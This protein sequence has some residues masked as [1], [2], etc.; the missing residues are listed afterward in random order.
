MNFNYQTCKIVLLGESGVGKTCIISQFVNQTFQEDVES[1][2]SGTFSSKTLIYNN[3]QVLKLEIW[4][5]A[6]QE[7][8]RSIA[9]MFYKEADVAILVYDITRKE[10]FE[11]IK[12]YWLNQI[13]E[14]SPENIILALCG[15]KSDLINEEQ[16]DEEEARNY[17]EE[18][19]AIFYPTSAKNDCGITD[20]FLQIAKK[21]TKSD[22]VRLKTDKDEIF[23]S[24]MTESIA[25]SQ[26][27]GSVIITKE[28]TKKTNGVKKK[29]CC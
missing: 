5:T 24:T 23:D 25:A 13:K 1:S 29:K 2:S 16:V 7:K 21:Y 8:Y 11:Q 9:S 12:Q 22:N 6:G 27:R 14:Y 20:L 4:D 28:D 19:D 17:A 18:I 26:T 15:N 10:S 3:N